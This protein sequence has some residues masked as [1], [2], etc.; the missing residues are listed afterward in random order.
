MD[1]VHI[2]DIATDDFW[3][4]SRFRSPRRWLIIT[5]CECKYGPAILF[6]DE[7]KNGK[8][9]FISCYDI[10]ILREACMKNIYQSFGDLDE[11]LL[12]DWCV[13][14]DDAFTHYIY[15]RFCLKEC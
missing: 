11:E 4:K 7:Y 12:R 2:L 8:Y 13:L 9:F 3:N 14:L 10:G 6:E 15:D 1:E 5:V